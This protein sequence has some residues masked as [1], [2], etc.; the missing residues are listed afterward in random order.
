MTIRILLILTIGLTVGF[1]RYL[2]PAICQKTEG[3]SQKIRPILSKCQVC[4]SGSPPI[5]GLSLTSRQGALNGGKSGPALNLSDSSHSLLYLQITAGKMPPNAPLSPEERAVVKEWL[6]SGAPWPQPDA[7]SAQRAG[8]DWWSL[9]PI[10]SRL[11]PIVKDKDWARNPID[12][13]ILSKLESNGLHPAPLADRATFIRRATF[14]LLGLPPTP[15]EIDA[16]VNDKSASSYEKLIDRLL[17]SPHYGERWGR[18]WLDVA[19]FAESQGYERDIIRDHAWRYRDYVIKSLNEDKP[20]MQF[21]REQIAG[22]VLT[23]ITPDGIIGTGFLVAGP[24][25]EVGNTVAASSVLRKRVREDELEDMVSAV[26]QTFL[27]MTVN[28]ARCHDHKFD[29]IPQKDYYRLKAALE[30]VKHGNRPILPQDEMNRRQVLI[31]ELKKRQTDIEGAIAA[32]EQ[33]IRQQL[34]SAHTGIAA[35]APAPFARWT[36]ERGPEDSISGLSG[37]LIGG[38]TVANGRLRLN[39]VTT[40]MRAGPLPVNIRD[41]TLEAWVVLPDLAQ[42]GGGIISIE[43]GEGR[44]FDSIVYGEREPRKW[45]AGSESFHRTKDLAAGEESNTDG[46]P[47]HI[48]AVYRSDN[49]IELYRNGISYAKSYVPAGTDRELRTFPAGESHLLFGLRHTGA[50]NGYFLGEIEEASLYNHALSAQEIAASFRAGY[51]RIRPE[52]I[53]RALPID[54]RNRRESLAT[55]LEKN[56]KEVVELESAPQVYAANPETPIP[57]FLLARGDVESPGEQVSAC[58]LS[59]VRT[60]QSDLNVGTNAPEA[61][62]RIKLADWITDPQNPL[63]AR[64]IVNRIWH[65]HFGNGIVNTPNDFGY[66][67]DRPSHPQLLDWLS[68]EFVRQ[69]WSIKKLHKLIMLSNTYR[70][71]STYNSAAAAKDADN[72]L[73]WRYS[74]RR[75]EGEEVRDTMLALSGRLNPQ[76]GGTSFRPFTVYVNNSH[77]YSLTDSDA[78]DMN[79]RTVYRICVNSAK[80]PMLETLDCPDPSTKTPRRSVTTTPLQALSLMNNSF[81]LRQARVMAERIAKEVGPDCSAQVKLAYRMAYGRSATAQEMNRTIPLARTHGMKS[82][83]WAILN[84]NEFLYIR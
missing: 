79:R 32:L 15:S 41:K 46:T 52:E 35:G 13:F 58:G 67:G 27:G 39:A 80:N 25:D 78:P 5:A 53:E 43:S 21:V 6:S 73:L 1:G 14:D 7:A 71:G 84:S 54:L 22:D 11:I 64:V 4:H 23:P 36:F 44:M 29:P 8:L 76:I 66:N 2:S 68:T 12:S 30:G 19:R 49:S 38:A 63:T 56:K 69:N 83:C 48:A 77:F 60:I 82:V 59:A 70:Q 75:L 37:Q 34:L 45:I 26:G 57:T 81:V 3:I 18:H 62:R 40:L 50:G 17:A 42:R 31:H 65:Y 72:R 33:P 28:C 24:W 9:Q 61:E 47:I 51:S 55:E 74:P 20:Y 10:I 16:F